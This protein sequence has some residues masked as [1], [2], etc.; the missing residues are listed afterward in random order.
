[1]Q[2]LGPQLPYRRQ[3]VSQHLTALRNGDIAYQQ[4]VPD[5]AHSC[6]IGCLPA[7]ANAYLSRRVLTP[8]VGDGSITTS[9]F[10]NRA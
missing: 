10:R 6:D 5:D 4:Q 1:M 7:Q 3:T 2:E 9:L 8:T